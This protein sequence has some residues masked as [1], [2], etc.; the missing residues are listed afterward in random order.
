MEAIDSHCSPRKFGYRKAQGV[1]RSA[2]KLCRQTVW[3]VLFSTG[4]FAAVSWAD[5]KKIT[6]KESIRT[7]FEKNF[8][9]RAMRNS[10]FA[11]KQDVGI[12]RSFLLPQ[13]SV[14]ERFTRTNNPPGVFMS[15]LNQERF[16]ETDFAIRSLNQPEPVNDMQTIAT[17]EQSLFSGKALLGWGMAKKEYESAQQDFARKK[18]ETALHVVA[19]YLRVKSAREYVS[20]NKMG[21]ED[22]TEHLRIAEVREKNGLGLYSDVLRAK[23]AVS[24]AEQRLVTAEKNMTLAKKAMGLILGSGDSV[25]VADEGVEFSSLPIEP[26]IGS[27]SARKDVR[28]MELRYENAGNSVRLAQSRYLPNLGIRASY[29]LNDHNNVFGNEGESWWLIGVLKW[30]LFDGAGREYEYSK[31]RYK[32][33]EVGEQL[34]GMKNLV[35]F[36]IAEASLGLEEARKVRDLA[37]SALATAEEGKKLV[38]SRY[39]NSLSPLVDLLDVQ[40]SV[41][42]ARAGL[43]AKEN[44]YQLAVMRLHYETGTILQALGVE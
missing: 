15:K 22:T 24:E 20:V 23:T 16:R 26:A 3:V 17:V 6:L 30:D 14:E 41:E 19:A 43:A 35:S 7:A 44:D 4:L 40:L 29:Q 21:L 25:D 10:V 32:Q 18:E 27:I 38:K 31:A 39:T 36:K 2:R 28:A 42:T 12:A 13:I 33:N 37:R 34:S 5:E 8:E 11:S 9:I 1:A